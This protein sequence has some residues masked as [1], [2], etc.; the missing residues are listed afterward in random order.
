MQKF[1]MNVDLPPTGSMENDPSLL[2]LKVYGCTHFPLGFVGGKV[3]GCS[4]KNHACPGKVL[5]MMASL[6]GRG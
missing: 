6:T 3:A 4:A 1:W 5:L 2:H